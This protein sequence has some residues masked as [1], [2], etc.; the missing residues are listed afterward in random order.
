[1]K[2]MPKVYVAGPYRNPSRRV[3]NRNIMY[4]RDVGLAAI[5]KGWNALIPHANTGHLDMLAPDIGDRFWLASTMD[6]MRVCDAVVLVEGWENSIGTQAEIAEAKRLGI[7][8]FESAQQ[9]PQADD[10]YRA[11]A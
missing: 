4:A 3:I 1:M 5:R 8:V 6:W 7:P 9:L 10:F 11:A 2:T